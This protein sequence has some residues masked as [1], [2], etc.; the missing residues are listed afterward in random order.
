MPT[1]APSSSR[2]CLPT[3]NFLPST[4]TLT[5]R[6]SQEKD[7]ADHHAIVPDGYN[8][9]RDKFASEAVGVK[10]LG[11]PFFRKYTTTVQDVTG[12]MAPGAQGVNHGTPPLLSSL[13]QCRG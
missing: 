1:A 4:H 12:L 5:S 9:G 6:V 2:R 13:N 3:P 10:K 7:L 11:F 8:I